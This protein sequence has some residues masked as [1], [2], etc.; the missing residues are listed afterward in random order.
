MTDKIKILPHMTEAE[1]TVLAFILY[2]PDALPDFHEDVAAT[3]FY[4]DDHRLIWEAM[5]QISSNGD[6]PDLVSVAT[7]LKSKGLLET[8]GGF[9][10]LNELQGLVVTAGQAHTHARLIHEKAVRRQLIKLADELR[11]RAF[12]EGGEQT[13]DIVAET[14]KAL[15]ISVDRLTQNSAEMLGDAVDDVVAAAQEMYENGAEVSGISTGFVDIDRKTA[16]LHPG[17]LTI[18]AARPAMGKTAFALNVAANIAK[19]IPVLI[20]SLEM[21][22]SELASRFVSLVGRVNAAHI[23]TGSMDSDEWTRFSLAAH[24][25]KQLHLAIDDTSGLSISDIRSRATRVAAQFGQLGLVV[26]DYLQLVSGSKLSAREGRTQEMAEVSRGLKA[27][28][29]DLKCPVLALS[30][31]NRAVES[32][33]DKRPM[34]ADIRESGAIEQDADLIAFIYRDEKYNPNTEDRNVAEIIIGKHRSGPT[35]TVRLRFDGQYTR[36][37]N[38]EESND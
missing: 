3:D 12:D 15:S 13:Q 8:V 37:D 19:E 24:D 26:V 7:H 18:L 20:F 10:Y 34:M 1:Q 6:E 11:D 5:V 38:L 25:L 36:F 17:A 16:G 29:K 23:K 27:I 9:A 32:R 35:G 22:K 28:A 14:Q 4:G 30:Q 2:R 21:S 31:L 33:P